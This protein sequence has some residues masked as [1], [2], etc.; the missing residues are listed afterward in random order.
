MPPFVCL[1][2]FNAAE[3]WEISGNKRKLCSTSQRNVLTLA[4]ANPTVLPAD[5][6]LSYPIT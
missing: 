4:G 6:F 3:W 1:N 2:P 5:W